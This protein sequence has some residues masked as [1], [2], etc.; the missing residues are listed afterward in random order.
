MT[1]KTMQTLTDE[2][3]R[4]WDAFQAAVAALQSYAKGCKVAS[5]REAKADL[6][7][8]AQVT[9]EVDRL[10]VPCP[11]RQLNTAILAHVLHHTPGIDLTAKTLQNVYLPAL[12]ATTP[13]CIRSGRQWLWYANAGRSKETT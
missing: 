1:D 7:K 12:R 5:V 13:H 11:G 9:A 4:T 10:L 3:T 2:V 6:A 8:L